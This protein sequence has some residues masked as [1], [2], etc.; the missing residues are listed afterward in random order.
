MNDY[1]QKILR[2]QPI[3]YEAFL[4]KLPEAFRR[5]HREL[6]ATEKV[7]GNRWLVF[8]LDEAA[9]KELQAV[10]QRPV[11][12]VDAAQKGQLSPPWHRGQFSSRLP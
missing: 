9:F 6:F 4:K 3:N 10:A 11:S 2:G 1:L 5:R 8:I 7:K 12:R